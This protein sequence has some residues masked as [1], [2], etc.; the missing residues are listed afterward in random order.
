[1]PADQGPSEPNRRE[2]WS[3]LRRDRVSLWPGIQQDFADAREKWREFIAEVRQ[4]RQLDHRMKQRI[5]GVENPTPRQFRDAV[6]SIDG[7]LRELKRIEQR[8]LRDERKRR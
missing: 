6:K 1:V 2:F 5:T 3:D 4:R 8:V 7:E